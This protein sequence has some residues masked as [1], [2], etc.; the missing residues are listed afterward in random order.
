MAEGGRGGLAR[1]G[2]TLADAH[3]ALLARF[4]FLEPDFRTWRERLDARLAAPDL[5]T[6]AAERDLDDLAMEL[7]A[8]WLGAVR[9]HAAGILKSPPHF[10][11][12]RTLDGGRYDF[13]YD[14]WGKPDAFERAYGET[15]ETAD[16]WS[17]RHFF[18]GNAMSALA[19]LL[20]QCRKT[21]DKPRISILGH[22]G[23]FEILRLMEILAGQDIAARFT[24]DQTSFNAFLRKG[25]GDVVIFEPVYADARLSVWDDA[26]FFAAWRARPNRAATV[27]AVD[28]S[29]VGDRFD[30]AAFLARLAPHPPALV[31]QA[32]S[33]LKLHQLGLEFANMGILSVFAPDNSELFNNAVHNLRSTRQTLG[34]GA[35]FEE[36]YAIEYPML[37]GGELFRTHCARVFDNNARAARALQG[38]GGLIVRVAHP[39]LG[40]ARDKPWAVAPVCVLGLR[41]GTG[42][43]KLFLRQVLQTEARR[44]GLLFQ[45]GSSFGFRGHRFE[46][47]VSDEPG[48]ATVR[49]AMGARDGP[50]ADGA[51]ALLKEVGAH[52]SFA[53][54]RAA[55]PDIRLPG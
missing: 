22:K 9:S 10:R 28:T 46:M 38:T 27:I 33:A 34:T 54:L 7:R 43:D 53:A 11:L 3:R 1:E 16:G 24:A 47:G 20:L 8:L 37:A 14:R 17:R 18:F 41:E 55:Y 45:S 42:D 13:P 51:I 50:S 21:L 4:A 48:E 12:A 35:N 2:R 29:L 44:R 6:L 5:E 49:L 15:L 26:P 30:M 23:Y 25:G 32:V 39:A 36:Y 31:V 19:T 52:G 40:P